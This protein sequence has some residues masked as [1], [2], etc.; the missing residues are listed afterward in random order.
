[1]TA[2]QPDDHELDAVA[3]SLPTADA[4]RARA[5]EIRTSLLA[6]AAARTQLPRGPKLH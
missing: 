5:E 2:W 4:D 1:M 3:R 6:S